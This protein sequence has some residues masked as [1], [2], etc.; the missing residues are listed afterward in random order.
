M[1]TAYLSMFLIA[2]LKV[3][4]RDPMNLENQKWGKNNSLQQPHK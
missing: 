4:S 2:T 1:I 3:H